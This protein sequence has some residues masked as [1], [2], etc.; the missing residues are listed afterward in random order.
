MALSKRHLILA[1]TATTLGIGGVL[2]PGATAMASTPAQSVTVAA[3][4]SQSTTTATTG[5]PAAQPDDYYCEWV[6][7][8]DEWGNWYYEE[9]CYW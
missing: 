5:A 8:W 4:A 6:Y 1:A 9:V 2:L 7:V 3:P